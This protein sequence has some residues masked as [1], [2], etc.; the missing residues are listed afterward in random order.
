MAH[1]SHRD[2]Q[3][4][5][6][7]GFLCGGGNADVA[8]LHGEDAAQAMKQDA[9]VAVRR[10]DRPLD[11]VCSCAGACGDSRRR[12]FAAEGA[13]RA[14]GRS[15]NGRRPAELA[16][17]AKFHFPRSNCVG[18]AQ[19]VVHA[20]P[21]LHTIALKPPLGGYACAFHERRVDTPAGSIPRPAPS[22]PGKRAPMTRNR[23]GTS[24]A[25][26]RARPPGCCARRSPSPTGWRGISTAPSWWTGPCRPGGA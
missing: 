5:A 19:S 9:K 6:G 15:T 7:L 2:D 4:A 10:C 25:T 3:R 24:G 1:P 23:L 21:Q 16:R 14:S 26:A 11:G 18:S 20:R 8:W 22:D 12:M 17:R 13:G